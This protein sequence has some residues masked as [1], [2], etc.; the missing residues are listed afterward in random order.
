VAVVSGLFD[1]LSVIR[2]PAVMAGLSPAQRHVLV[3]IAT[4]T[5]RT[6]WAEPT[7]PG[8]AQ[9]TGYAERSVYRLV[10]QLV[11]AGRLERA[12]GSGR[13]HRARFH[14][15]HN[16]DP[17]S[18]THGQVNDVNLTETLTETLTP[19]SG[20]G[21]GNGEVLTNRDSVRRALPPWVAQGISLREWQ[22]RERQAGRLASFKQADHR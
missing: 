6:G 16:P 5:D 18:L 15:I 22:R 17:R 7:F 3:A 11:D 2:D 21:V 9:M 12:G 20:S 10:A 14:I 4:Y 1:T 13:G 8:L 19:R